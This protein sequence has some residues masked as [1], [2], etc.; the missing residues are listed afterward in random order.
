MNGGSQLLVLRRDEGAGRYPIHAL[1]GPATAQMFGE[2]GVR[3]D[4]EG[5]ALEVLASRFDHEIR[6]ILNPKGGR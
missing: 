3:E 5:R 2:A 1:T 4:I 6:R